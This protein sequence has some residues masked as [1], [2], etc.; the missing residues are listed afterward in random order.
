MKVSCAPRG[1]GRKSIARFASTNPNSRRH[2]PN[3]GAAAATAGAATTAT[4]L[5]A[6]GDA[7]KA[8]GATAAALLQGVV[9]ERRF[10]KFTVETVKTEAAARKLLADRGVPHYWDLCAA[11][12]PE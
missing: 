6:K 5:G 4:R 9:K 3:L 12:T 7:A 11:F 10:K 2:S 1:S 8:T